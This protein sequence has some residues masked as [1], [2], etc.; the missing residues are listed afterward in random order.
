MKKILIFLFLPVLSFGFDLGVKVGSS[1]IS[2]ENKTYFIDGSS[3]IYIN[4]YIFAFKKNVV[5]LSFDFVYGKSRS[6]NSEE[7]YR[8]F[9]GNI[10]FFIN[11]VSDIGTPEIFILS[12]YVNPMKRKAG[13]I[14]GYFGG[15]ISSNK[16]KID[17]KSF[18][19]KAYQWF[20]GLRW[21]YIERLG[22]GFEYKFKRFNTKSIK[23]IE[24]YF[25]N[26]VAL[27]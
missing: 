12:G 18:K 10:I 27:F 1:E 15:G 5:G 16:V 23:Y 24:H 25:F 2:L 19:D 21:M 8:A 13:R 20:L 17:E 22:M 7:F 14:D 11:L 9:E 26:I 4:K 6:L 3:D